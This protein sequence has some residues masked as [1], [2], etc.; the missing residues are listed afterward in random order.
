MN[1]MIDLNL[2]LVGRF[3]MINFFLENKVVSMN[4]KYLFFMIILVFIK[5]FFI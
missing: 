5:M 2:F 3:N 4:K 1:L